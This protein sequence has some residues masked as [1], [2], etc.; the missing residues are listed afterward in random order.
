MQVQDRVFVTRD[1]DADYLSPFGEK[2][3][4]IRRGSSGKVREILGT[5]VW[6]DFGS[7]F[8]GLVPKEY[9]SERYVEPDS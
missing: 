5:E 4:I 3:Q 2:G 9:L 7:G 1:F 6:V 8:E